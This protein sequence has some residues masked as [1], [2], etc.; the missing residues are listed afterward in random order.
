MPTL[1]M[2]FVTVQKKSVYFIYLYQFTNIFS[3]F[4]STK[5]NFIYYHKT[6]FL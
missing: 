6:N 1:K 5:N 2:Q 3:T 4:T